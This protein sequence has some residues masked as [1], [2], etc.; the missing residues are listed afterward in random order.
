MNNKE[1]VAKLLERQSAG[2]DRDN[3]VVI[4][5]MRA[6]A[7][8]LFKRYGVPEFDYQSELETLS[9]AFSDD[10]NYRKAK[11]LVGLSV[12]FTGDDRVDRPLIIGAFALALGNVIRIGGD[13]NNPI[14][15]QYVQ[16]DFAAKSGISDFEIVDGLG[17]WVAIGNSSNYWDGHGKVNVEK[18][19]N[20]DRPSRANREEIP[21]GS[22]G[23]K[24][25]AKKM[26]DLT[27]QYLSDSY[28]END[29]RLL[30]NWARGVLKEKG[31]T[32]RED[33]MKTFADRLSDPLVVRY[34]KDPT[35]LYKNA[36][37]SK[38]F[39]TV[40]GKL[41]DV[42][43]G[44]CDCMTN[45][46]SCIAGMCG[47]GVTIRVAGCNPSR[48]TSYSHVY[49]LLHY[50]NENGTGGVDGFTGEK[51]VFVDVVY[52]KRLG[53]G[54]GYGMEPRRFIFFDTKI[55]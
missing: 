43:A 4:G 32:D 25:T 12:D 24:R 41:L 31:V 46:I 30:Q 1:L 26:K 11:K 51:N 16:K 29:R 38:E 50:N 28:F 10:E 34:M 20:L 18:Q 45:F 54:K 13:G 39:L 7:G 42:G 23:I 8:N 36:I 21:P 49:N 27:L 22:A 3:D 17:G 47:L 5:K 9:H 14:I 40:P 33:Y 37:Q 55:I 52:Q 35:Y 19:I 15:V 6:V 2:S 53:K 44:D 48:R